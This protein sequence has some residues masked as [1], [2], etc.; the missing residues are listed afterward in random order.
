MMRLTKCIRIGPDIADS[1]NN[2]KQASPEKSKHRSHDFLLDLC[3]SLYATVETHATER[4]NCHV[5][6]FQYDLVM[7]YPPQA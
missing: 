4:R 1:M 5:A 3:A 7:L 6:R 2:R